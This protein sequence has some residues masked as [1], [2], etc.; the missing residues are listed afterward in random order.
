VPKVIP[1][2]SAREFAELAAFLRFFSTTVLGIAEADP[3]HPGNVLDL[4]VALLGKSK[5]SCWAAT[6]DS[7]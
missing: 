7:S 5:V 4:S 3:V 2:A 1:E 6:G